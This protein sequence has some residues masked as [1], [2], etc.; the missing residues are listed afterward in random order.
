MIKYFSIFLVCA[1]SANAIASENLEERVN[2]LEIKV[3]ELEKLIK[4][5]PKTKPLTTSAKQSAA[6]TGLT[7]SEWSYSYEQERSSGYYR[8]FYTL[9]NSYEKDIKLIDGS[10]QF[11]DLLGER[12]YGIKI[13]PDLKIASGKSIK[14]GGTYRINRFMNEQLRMKDMAKEDVVATLVIRKIVFSD[15]SILEM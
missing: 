2:A 1:L 4:T 11:K 9:V 8:I 7:L 12:L 14:D 6:K 13:T 15:N 5:T 3:I 10:L